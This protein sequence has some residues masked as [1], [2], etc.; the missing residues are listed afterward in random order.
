MGSDAIDDVVVGDRGGRK[1]NSGRLVTDCLEQGLE[2][3]G[4]SLKYP[5]G[6]VTSISR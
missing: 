2:S 5:L 1:I 6:E 3:S 4:F